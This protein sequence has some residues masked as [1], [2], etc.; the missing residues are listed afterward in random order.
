MKCYVIPE[1]GRSAKGTAIVNLLQL[2]GGEKI[3]ALFP[4]TNEASENN[5][6]V[7]ATRGGVI[8]KT[9]LSDFDNIRKG[10][11]IAQNLRE[12]D[13]L[14]AAMLSSG[15]DEFM[16]GTSSGKCIRFHERDVR[17]MGRAAAGVRAIQLQEDDS[18]V[19]MVKVTPDSNVF[20]VTENG[21]GKCTPED[22]YRG[23]RRGGKGIIA[24]NI[25]DKT[26]P[27]VG[28]KMI[29]GDEDIM[30]IRDDG[31]VIRMPAEQISTNVNRNTQGVRLMR[32]DEG[33]RVVSVA[34]APH[35]EEVQDEE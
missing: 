29:S 1:A 12:G 3:T 9:P 14:I 34:V 11:I 24:M 5:Y 13:E 32:V 17:A 23:Q 8:K 18:V 25:N 21:M 6:L 31:T 35:A 7:M 2:Q 10:G 15:D 22:A 27:L 26:G 33:T 30:L 28:L 16:I 19:D 20:A 4:V